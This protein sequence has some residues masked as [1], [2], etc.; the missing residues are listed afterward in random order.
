MLNKA[1]H[2]ASGARIPHAGP[3]PLMEMQILA[4]LSTFSGE[5][6]TK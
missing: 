3:T 6:L 1:P 4:K 5:T 2:P